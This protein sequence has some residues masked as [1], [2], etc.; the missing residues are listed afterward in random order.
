MKYNQLSKQIT[1]SI[2]RWSFK[3]RLQKSQRK[4]RLSRLQVSNIEQ[5]VAL[6]IRGETKKLIKIPICY[7][8]TFIVYGLIIGDKVETDKLS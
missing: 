7:G 1:V 8:Y 6:Y 4:Q 3:W 5:L 2:V